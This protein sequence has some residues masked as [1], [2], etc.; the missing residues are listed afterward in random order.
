MTY[1]PALRELGRG[2][3]IHRLVLSTL[4]LKRGSRLRQQT[5]P[6]PRVMLVLSS[7]LAYRSSRPSDGDMRL[8]VRLTAC[9]RGSPYLTRLGSAALLPRPAS[10]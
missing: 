3:G 9:A 4:A 7:D 10:A 2:A 1:G 6:K 5:D 8:L